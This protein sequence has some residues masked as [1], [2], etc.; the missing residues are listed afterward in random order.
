MSNNKIAK[1]FDKFI[2]SEHQKQSEI[3]PIM[4]VDLT[5]LF[6]MYVDEKKISIISV[7]AVAEAI[8]EKMKLDGIELWQKQFASPDAEILKIDEGK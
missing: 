3:G 8:S 5:K 2:E 6:S 7:A 1:L 4:L